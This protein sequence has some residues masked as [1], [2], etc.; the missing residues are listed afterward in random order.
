M[1]SDFKKPP[2]RLV[3]V[4]KI[5]FV[6]L[7]SAFAG[8]LLATQVTAFYYRYPENFGVP[9]VPRVLGDGI[10][11]YQPLQFLL[12][13]SLYKGTGM[14]IG[15]SIFFSCVV[16]GF[17]GGGWFG[18]SHKKNENDNLYGSAEWG[19]PRDPHLRLCEHH[20]LVL[21][22]STD[23]SNLIVDNR[24]THAII[25]A[26]TGSGKS[27]G[28]VILTLLSYPESVI[29]ADIKGELASKTAGAR[30]GWSDIFIFNPLS[31]DNITRINPLTEIHLGMTAISNCEELAGSI[32][33]PASENSDQHWVQ[34]SREWM[35]AMLLYILHCEKRENVHLGFLYELSSIGPTNSATGTGFGQLLAQCKINPHSDPTVDRDFRA[36]EKY[37]RDTG[38]S[39]VNTPEREAGSVASTMSKHLDAFRN[40]KIVRA[41]S[42]STFAL[43]SLIDAKRP[44]TLYITAPPN[45]LPVIASIIRVLFEMTCRIVLEKEP[46]RADTGKKTTLVMDPKASPLWQ[47][48]KNSF[49]APSATADAVDSWPKLEGRNNVLFLLDEAPRYAKLEAIEKSISLIRSYGGRIVLVA[50]AISQLEKIYGKDSDIF[51]NTGVKLFLGIAEIEEAKRVSELVGVTTRAFSTRGYSRQAASFIDS[52][53]NQNINYSQRQLIN[54]DEVMRLSTDSNKPL[55]ILIIEGLRPMKIERA[56]YFKFSR[57]QRATEIPFVPIIPDQAIVSPWDNIAPSVSDETEKKNTARH[58]EVKDNDNIFHHI[59]GKNGPSPK[60]TNK[61]AP[62]DSDDNSDN[63]AI[64]PSDLAASESMHYSPPPSVSDKSDVMIVP[65]AVSKMASRATNAINKQSKSMPP[66]ETNNNSKNW[67]WGDRKWRPNGTPKNTDVPKNKGA[68]QSSIPRVVGEKQNKNNDRGGKSDVNPN[69]ANKKFTGEKT[70]VPPVAPNSDTPPPNKMNSWAK[71]VISLMKNESQ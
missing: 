64:L 57:F 1:S 29:V 41:M 35:K 39:I 53:V 14:T 71:M 68:E 38:K 32:V 7:L 60:P 25:A 24:N 21:G 44:Q 55:A 59:Y 63:A 15:W 8:C 45:D 13:A 48:M 42:Q 27:A 46:K 34:K 17:I 3:A 4:Q 70:T 16:L 10:H 40:P 65:R 33:P 11:F 50:Q 20:G 51:P 9:L 47:R 18:L 6:L 43:R 22:K 31:D 19:N 30:S 67:L 12:W 49:F 62:V 2:E 28:P 36:I 52:G 69:D 58:R 37:I 54:A 23:G 66:A 61:N 56:F 26:T 5:M